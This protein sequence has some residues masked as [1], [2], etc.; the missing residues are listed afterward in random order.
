MEIKDWNTNNYYG[1]FD[2]YIQAMWDDLWK[3]KEVK[4]YSTE[5]NEVLIIMIKKW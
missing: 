5:F 3:D 1:V 2:C 4:G